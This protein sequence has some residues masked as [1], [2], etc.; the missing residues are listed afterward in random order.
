MSATQ[1]VNELLQ[2]WAEGDQAAAEAIYA[3]YASQLCALAE[4]R[5]NQRLQARV[6]PED[7][8]QSVFRS[9]FRRTSDG[10]FSVDHSGALWRLLVRITVD[11]VSKQVRKH[12][13][14]KRDVQREAASD[15]LQILDQAAGPVDAA[16]FADEF[17]FLI[18]QLNDAECRILEADFAGESPSDIATALNCSLWTVRRTL[19][20]IRRLLEERLFGEK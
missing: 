11:K 14:E 20:R 9:F 3:R 6:A 8:V 5:L 4:A 18:S 10:E 13:A 17:E 19:R 2:R 12:R 16:A 7:I 1:S 15:D